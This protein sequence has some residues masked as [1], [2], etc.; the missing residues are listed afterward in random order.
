MKYDMSRQSNNRAQICWQKQD[1][2]TLLLSLGQHVNLTEI[3]SPA[4]GQSSSQS[5]TGST[6]RSRVSREQIRRTMTYEIRV[7]S[8]YYR[9]QYSTRTS[10]WRLLA[11]TWYQRI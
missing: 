3:Y 7:S 2:T 5:G 1:D 8:P 10:G 6:G 4:S 9:L 11:A